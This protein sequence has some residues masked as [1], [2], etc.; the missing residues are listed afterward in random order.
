MLVMFADDVYA[1]VTGKNEL[2]VRTKLS[3]VIADVITWLSKNEL[4]LNKET[5]Y[6]SCK[7][8]YSSCTNF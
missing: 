5:F 3:Q 2:E 6:S 4:M 8:F 1:S 7:T